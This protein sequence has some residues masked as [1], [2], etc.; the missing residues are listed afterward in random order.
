MKNCLA[1]LL[2][3]LFLGLSSSRSSRNRSFFSFRKVT[4]SL[5]TFGKSFK[6]S[7]V[8]WIYSVLDVRKLGDRFRQIETADAIPKYYFKEQRTINAVVVKVVDG[9]TVRVRHLGS[10]EFPPPFRDHTIIV[11]LAAIDCP[12]IAKFGNPDQP[13][14]QE[15]K[16][17]VQQKLFQKDIKLKL[18]G[19]D[20]YHRAVGRIS[21]KE[22]N[23]LYD[24]SEELL[25]KGL[26]VVY[27][28]KKVF[29]DEE[30]LE[31]WFSLE[32][33]AIQKKLG[34]WKDGVEKVELPSEFKQA[35]RSSAVSHSA[36]ARSFP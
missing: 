14:A 21:Y 19:M 16:S 17:F 9:D 1:V 31:K 35:L 32:N 2:F 28:G 11:R 12:E 6:Q 4:T 24:L 18:L 30:P 13:F 33:Q 8:K 26:A 15:A 23:R 5:A 22:N 34:M 7:S 29:L 27:R 36:T 20:F 3:L 10:R 25:K